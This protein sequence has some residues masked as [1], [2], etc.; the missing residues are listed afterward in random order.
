MYL[1]ANGND[2]MEYLV[3][4]G[5]APQEPS[6]KNGAARRGFAIFEL[7]WK[8]HV[9]NQRSNT[10]YVKSALNCSRGNQPDDD[11]EMDDDNGV[12]GEPRIMY[13]L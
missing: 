3:K 11:D 7:C 13:L 9:K 2:W 6:I 12:A 10:L 1:S 5:Q 4:A 8:T